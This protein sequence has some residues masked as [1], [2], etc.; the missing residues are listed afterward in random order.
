MPCSHHHDE[1]CSDFPDILDLFGPHSLGRFGSVRYWGTVVAMCRHAGPGA[2]Q[3]ARAAPCGDRH[4]AELR[5]HRAI[6]PAA[7]SWWIGH[8]ELHRL[9]AVDRTIAGEPRVGLACLQIGPC[10]IQGPCWDRMASACQAANEGS[11]SFASNAC[12]S[13]EGP[14][15]FVEMELGQHVWIEEPVIRIIISVGEITGIQK[16]ALNDFRMK[17]VRNSEVSARGK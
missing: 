5:L 7:G 3:R 1:N 16:P 17:N 8:R 10:Q 13:E 12:G 2:T 15:R 14:A 11:A 6:A 9:P 4:P